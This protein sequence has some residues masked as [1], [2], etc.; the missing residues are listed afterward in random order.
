MY[1]KTIIIDTEHFEN[2]GIEFEFS[3][4]H[5]K[6]DN[7]G[8]PW[9]PDDMPSFEYNI[10]DVQVCSNNE[11]EIKEALKEFDNM[12]DSEDSMVLEIIKR[13]IT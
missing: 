6:G 4:I 2:V 10:I 13:S 5:H 7:P 12:V 1:T 11:L 9:T 3:V 8:N